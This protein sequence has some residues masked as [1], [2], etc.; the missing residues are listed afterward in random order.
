[1]ER[2]LFPISAD[3]L[4]YGHINIIAKAQRL[5]NQQLTVV[6]LD[7]YSKK[8]TLSLT[9]RAQLTRDV[10]ATHWRN[11][12]RSTPPPVI[13]WQGMLHELMLA[14]G[15]FTVIRGLRNAAELHYERSLIKGYQA[16]LSP[17]LQQVQPLYLLCDEAYQDIS[18]SLVKNITLHG[19]DV[20]TF[21]P[22]PVKHQLERKLLNQQRVI[23]TG[24]IGAG[25]STIIPKLVKFIAKHYRIKAHY[26]NLD[27][28]VDTLYK[29]LAA[30]K[31]P[32]LKQQLTVHF[33]LKTQPSKAEIR[34]H[35]LTAS[36]SVAKAHLKFLELVMS[37]YIISTYRKI[38]VGCEGVIFIEAPQAAEYQ[39]LAESNGFVLFVSCHSTERQ[40]RLHKAARF[41]KAELE[42]RIKL[43][44]TEAVKLKQIKQQLN[45]FQ[46]GKLLLYDNNTNNRF[47]QLNALCKNLMAALNAYSS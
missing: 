17:S 15:V 36:R 32:T 10:L 2:A 40:K 16:Q 9:L 31:L 39:L 8:H 41:P 19:G 14:E 3:P 5:C 25:K 38:L 43:S 46:Y 34:K 44:G 37:P 4:T 47:T 33:K 35:I 7:N 20:T 29:Q 6:V 45:N 21:V 22:L 1:M 12:G 24:C 30:G 13:A 18:S 27:T 23:V 28:V 26:I 42:Q 11:I